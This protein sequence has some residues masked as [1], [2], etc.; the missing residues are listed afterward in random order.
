MELCYFFVGLEVV[1]NTALDTGIVR[2]M[3]VFVTLVTM[4]M[5][6]VRLCVPITVLSPVTASINA[7]DVTQASQVGLLRLFLVASP[8]FPFKDTRNVHYLYMCFKTIL[9]TKS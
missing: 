5:T 7:V 4:E 6:V 9:H 8:D 2:A 3:S 1:R